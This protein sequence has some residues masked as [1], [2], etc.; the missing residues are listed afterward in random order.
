MLPIGM[1]SLLIGLLIGCWFVGIGNLNPLN[2]SWLLTGND[3]TSHQLSFEFFRSAPLIQW[4]LTSTPGLI[5]GSGQVLAS[6]NGLFG[7]VPRS[8]E[9]YVKDR[10]AQN[11]SDLQTGKLDKKK[12]YVIIDQTTWANYRER[13]GTQATSLIIDGFTVIVSKP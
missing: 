13:L 5:S 10:N 7:F 12:I 4:P 11:E 2:Y 8:I 9:T 1:P 3:A 6:A